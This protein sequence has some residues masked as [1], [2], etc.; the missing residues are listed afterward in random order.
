MLGKRKKSLVDKDN[1]YPRPD[2][3]DN[4]IE[5]IKSNTVYSDP[6]ELRSIDITDMLL[7]I[8]Y[9]ARKA[10]TQRLNAHKRPVDMPDKAILNLALEQM[11][12]LANDYSR[13]EQ[14]VIANHLFDAC[15]SIEKAIE[16]NGQPKIR[17]L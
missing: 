10:W 3:P 8:K 13:A 4:F 16:Y 7:D 6:P 5:P 1:P 12:A 2:L 11:N 17:Q 15:R 14:S 9:K